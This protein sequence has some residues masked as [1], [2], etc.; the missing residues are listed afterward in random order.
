MTSEHEAP[1]GQGAHAQSPTP[2]KP[3]ML[4]TGATGAI[5]SEIA[6]QAAAAGYV[7]AVHGSSQARVDA[8]IDTIRCRVPEAELTPLPGDFRD[9][10]AIAA[11]ISRLVA[12]QGGLHSVVHC[13]ITGEPGVTGLFEKTDPRSYGAHAA[14]VMGSFQQLCFHALPHLSRTGGAIV[15]LASDAG[16]FA[17]PRQAIV[18]GAFGGLVVFARNLALE[19]ARDGVRINCI[20]PSFVENTPAFEKYAAGGRGETARSR[21]GRGLP[22]PADIAP[23]AIFLCGP[24]ARKITG[25]S[26]SVNGGLNA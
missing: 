23:L 5:G 16:R 21:A 15:A 22:S 1:T 14:L 12:A 8:A 3:V 11:M 7:V 4:V 13:A 25:Q 24:G 18:G 17:A 20:T 19:V 9:G 10:D 26:I 2:A 6:A